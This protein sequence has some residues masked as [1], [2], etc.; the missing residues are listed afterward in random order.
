[1]AIYRLEVKVIGR[2]SGRSACAAAAY[3]AAERIVDQ[4]T[5][6]VHDYARRGGVEHAEILAPE[7]A[8]AWVQD[9]A[10]LWNAVEAAE[11]RLRWMAERTAAD[12]PG[13]ERLSAMEVVAGLLGRAGTDP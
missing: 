5:G 1:M 4:R 3:R 11:R 12:T 7:T 8:P 10:A 13:S 6:Q 2:T 9:R